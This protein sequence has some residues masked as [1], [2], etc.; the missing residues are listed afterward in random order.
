MQN[1][2][3]IKTPLTELVVTAAANAYQFD[4]T[5]C[6]GFAYQLVISDS[7]GL[8]SCSVTLQRSINGTNWEADGDVVNITGD[9]ALELLVAS[10]PLA[11]NYYRLS[12]GWG[13]G[14]FTVNG[15]ALGKTFGGSGSTIIESGGGGGGGSGTVTSVG[16]SVP[17][18]LLA[19]SG[20]PVTTSGTLAVT[21]PTRTAN[22]VFAGPTSGGAATPTFRALVDDDI[23]SISTDKLDAGTLPIA[24][25]GTNS[26]AA[27][28]NNRVMQ[29]S[30]GAIVEAAAITASRA[31]ASDANGIPVASATTAT[32][33]GYVNGVTSAIQTQLNGKITGGGT[34][35]VGRFPVY[36]DTS[37]GSLTQAGGLGWSNAFGTND[38]II[39]SN[40][41]INFRVA[42]ASGVDAA[43][44]NSAGSFQ[45]EVSGTHIGVLNSSTNVTLGVTGARFNGC[46]LK[47]DLQMS[48]A[49]IVLETAGRGIQIKEGSNAKMGQATLVAGTVTV[50]TT[51]V[52]STTSRIFLTCAV[53]GGTQGILSV[54]AVTNATSFVINS[55]NAGDTSTV[56]W[57]ILDAS[58]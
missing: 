58:P 17:S 22:T 31:L 8:A 39:Y 27:L 46:F 44:F 40:G 15:N 37:G 29:S 26:T 51:A 3:V 4:V 23:P 28:N 56:N 12:F 35:V 48:T 52:S 21:L 11:G 24:R 36:N 42:G 32:E 55:S 50:S 33:L 18:A 45:M 19:V 54:G 16:M 1:L 2:N 6:G 43:Y 10:Q 5:G 41:T 7:A 20:S 25:G 14:T 13:A 49:N 30:G 57:L 47:A 53:V 38:P 34:T 9:G